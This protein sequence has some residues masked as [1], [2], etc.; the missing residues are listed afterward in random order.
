MTPVGGFQYCRLPKLLQTFETLA[1][2][3]CR[4]EP[5]ARRSPDAVRAN[6]RRERFSECREHL[7]LAPFAFASGEPDDFAGGAEGHG[8]FDGLIEVLADADVGIEALEPD[9][10]I[11]G[12]A[13]HR[14]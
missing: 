4:H 6:V 13:Q 12:T 5:R 1:W 14:A 7:R 9:S 10:I 8:E 2:V 3:P 11:A